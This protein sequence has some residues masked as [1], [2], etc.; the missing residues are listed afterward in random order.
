MVR[1]ACHQAIRVAPICVVGEA[2]TSLSP[3]EH[4]ARAWAEYI[5]LGPWEQITE[6]GKSM[7]FSHVRVF[8]RAMA[9]LEPSEGVV[10]AACEAYDHD[11]TEE[12]GTVGVGMRM[13]L[14]AALRELAKEEG[15][16]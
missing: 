16:G 7:V 10:Q 8:L 3:R 13:A 11:L 2:M 5:Q 14:E 6:A 12:C 4:L 1:R 9:T 15:Q